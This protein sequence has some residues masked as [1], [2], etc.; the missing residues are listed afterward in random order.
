MQR[1]LSVELDIIHL[2]DIARELNVSP[3][4]VNNWKKRDKVPYKYI[5]KIREIETYKFQ[6]KFSENDDSNSTR[7]P[8]NLDP[9]F[10]E[11]N[12][13]TS[14]KD[15]IIKL[16]LFFKNILF[17]YYKFIIFFTSS[18]VFITALY[19]QYFAPINYKVNLSILPVNNENNN[20]SIGGIAS[21]FGINI[22]SSD[23]NLASVRLIPDLIFSRSLLTSL[24]MRKVYSPMEKNKIPLIE[25]Y[26]GKSIP[27]NPYK[28][29]HL[30]NGTSML[31]SSISCSSNIVR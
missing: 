27:N 13:E 22:T 1:I 30:K 15:D 19:V 24:L 25:H 17:K 14:L 9:Y 12:D 2:S 18:S 31:K 11:G 10:L 23:N 8:K 7:I 4:V 21:Q 20:K 29:I 16:I 26:F 5:K 28:E 3:Q 6:N